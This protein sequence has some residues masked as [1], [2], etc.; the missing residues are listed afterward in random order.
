[1][2]FGLLTVGLLSA[3]GCTRRF[4]QR[5]ADAEVDTILATK[6]KY[7]QWKLGDYYVWPHPL[8]RFADP[9][10]WNRPP[11]PPDDPAAWDLSPHP[12]RP[13]FRGHAYWQGTGYLDLMSKWDK[14]NRA[15]ME[16]QK[17][18]PPVEVEAEKEPTLPG[19]TKTFDQRMADIDAQILR[20]LNQ[21]VTTTGLKYDDFMAGTDISKSPTSKP[22]M[23]DM[24][25]VVQLGFLN[26]QQFQSQREALYLTCLALTAQRFA[27]I[28]QPY[29]TEV[30]L[31]QRSGR[32]SPLGESSNWQS[33][34]NTG[35]TKLFS[36]GALLL[37]NFANQTVY[38]LG[39]MNLSSVSTINLDFVQP[40]LAGGG[41]AVA[42]EP[43]TQAE[44]DVVYAIRDFF[45][46]R[47]EYYVFW[48][49]GQA[50]FIPGV[51][52]GASTIIPATTAEPNPFVPGPF[53]L[54][55][56]ANPATVQVPPQPPLGAVFGAGVV[57]TPQG[58]LSTIGERA[59]LVNYYKN[60]Q[61]LQRFLVLLRAYVEGGLANQVQA[62]LVEQQLLSSISVALTNHAN[63]RISLDQLKQQLGLPMTVP[64]DLDPAPLQPII[65]LTTNYEKLFVDTERV[66]YNSL[67]YGR[68]L[69]PKQLRP[70]LHRL[71]ERTQ[72]LRDTTTRERILKRWPYWES[73]GRDQS[74]ADRISTLRKR[75]LELREE[76]YQLRRKRGEQ[77]GETLPEEDARR[78]R[79]LY[80]DSDLAEL[81]LTLSVYELE[82]WKGDKKT[83]LEQLQQQRQ[84]N[85]A[86]RRVHAALLA[87]AGGAVVER[88]EQIKKAWPPLPSVCAAGVDLLSAPEDEAILA[89]ERTVMNSR[90]DLMNV[91]AQLVDG[92]RKIRVAANALMGTFTVDYHFASSTP[93]G[94][95]RPF[96]F[97]GTSNVNQL[98][99]NMSPPI[100]RILQRNNYRST[101]IYFQQARRNLMGYEDQL[102]FNVRLDLRNLVAAANSVHRV[103]KRAIELAYM[104]VDQALQAFSQ[105]QA[106]P[107]SGL[108]PAGLV[109]PVAQRPQ[110]GD[111]AAL[112]QQLLTTQSS[113]L[114]AQNNLYSTWIGYL[115]ARMY[116]FR[117]LGTI[118]F[119]NRGVWI[120]DDSA[121]PCKSTDN[122]DQPA[123]SGQP[124]GSGQQ[125]PSRP[126]RLP[127]PRPEPAAQDPA[128]E[129][130]H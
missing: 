109:G 61:N 9:T 114:T 126:E 33:T 74:A 8:S 97:L 52:P 13:I 54:P 89:T 25:Q 113:L 58:Y 29:L 101:L 80:F 73:L 107:V 63:Y 122:N 71:L 119:D 102:L 53:A 37:F 34:A 94:V 69:Q 129:P 96:S 4:F 45:R 83:E 112:T 70:R 68:T 51:T 6:D 105:P 31:R 82:P 125:Q 20:E 40:F 104:Q 67:E 92:W 116:F 23:L 99:L 27:F 72:L 43:L 14:E 120:D 57:P 3:S 12:Q 46:F 36:T 88:Q 15:R 85:E 2:L 1:M 47:Q 127:E 115:N 90:V 19:E 50:I 60:I 30:L 117:D 17:K 108:E 62:G 76:L 48:A 44:R 11:M 95:A 42:L 128:L 91:R 77:P 24:D 5:R 22:F 55:L 75:V 39:Q 130:A 86:F 110:V 10:D 124:L 56:V 121:C 28:A 32:N 41:R 16:E 81:E 66:T 65:D 84:A 106:P 111:P 78:E 59:T 103:Q 100:V 18:T 93:T 87:V 26:S 118:Q 64:I 79:E 123:G 98:Y 38:N 21:P 35:F 49:A 7:P